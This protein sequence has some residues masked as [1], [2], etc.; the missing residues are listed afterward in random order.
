M[1][2]ARLAP[3]KKETSGRV[4]TEAVRVVLAATAGSLVIAYR[5]GL[6]AGGAAVSSLAK[7]CRRR[8][9]E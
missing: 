1:G 4:V 6:R 8:G 3:K 9:M 7:D 5:D 2:W